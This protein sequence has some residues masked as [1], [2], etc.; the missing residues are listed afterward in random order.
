MEG[1]AR[2]GEEGRRGRV[3]Q[4]GWPHAGVGR[5]ARRVAARKGEE[6]CEAGRVATRRS[7][8]GRKEGDRTQG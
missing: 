2:R 6:G 7:E 3:R 5:G 1:G 8:E 4:G